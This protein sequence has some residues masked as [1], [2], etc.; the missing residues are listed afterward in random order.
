MN[1]GLIP[2]RP[3]DAIEDLSARPADRLLGSAEHGTVTTCSLVQHLDAVQSQVGESCVGEALASSIMMTARRM[4]IPLARPS[5]KAIYDFARL[6]D[7]PRAPLRDNGCRPRAAMA[8]ISGYGIVAAARWRATPETIN[9]APPLD[10]FAASLGAKLREYYR[11]PSGTGCA[12]GVRR[13]LA[14]GYVPVF[15]MPVDAAYRAATKT[16]DGV[17]SEIEGYHMQAVVACEPGALVVLNSWGTGWGDGGFIRI[18]D[19]AF[20][21]VAFDVLVPTLVPR[22]VS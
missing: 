10:V 6:I 15:G 3:E 17:S 8:G 7:D 9:D 11:I 18:T 1:L 2:D 13:A 19:A 4:G 14:S 16:V 22:S 20:D 12:S 5:A 21:A